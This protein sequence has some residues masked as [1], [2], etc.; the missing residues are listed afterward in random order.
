MFRGVVLAVVIGLSPASLFASPITEIAGFTEGCF[1]TACDSFSDLAVQTPFTF[2]GTSF[3]F[4]D[5]TS[6]SGFSIGSISRLSTSAGNF[7]GDLPFTLQIVFTAPT[8]T[9]PSPTYGATIQGQLHG[10]GGGAWIDFDNEV[11]KVTFASGEFFFGV[12][13]IG[14][15]VGGVTSL[16]KGETTNIL[17]Q[18]YGAQQ[19]SEVSTTAVPEPTSL[20]LLGMGLVA[21]GWLARRRSAH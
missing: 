11:Q 15:E 20:A 18:I 5:V 7:T 8:G 14:T 21:C 9:F 17:G 3:S 13:D 6:V 19:Q 1:G 2:D 16:D 4:L 10:G 12:F